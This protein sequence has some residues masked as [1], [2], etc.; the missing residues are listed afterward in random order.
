MENLA[1]RS[2]DLRTSGLWAQHASIAPLCLYNNNK[3]HFY[4]KPLQ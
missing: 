2:F 1:E 3:K 4:F